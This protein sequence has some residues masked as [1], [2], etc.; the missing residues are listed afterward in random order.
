MNPLP[1]IDSLYSSSPELKKLLLLHSSC[2]ADMAR[3][4]IDSRA[5]TDIDRDFVYE[6][7]MLHDIGIFLCD[8]PSIHCHGTLPYIA[9]GIA[10]AGLLEAYDLPRHALVCERHTG[11]GLSKEDII[12]GNLP[13]PHRDMLPIS[14]EEQLICYADKFYS[15]SGDPGRRKPLDRVM[16]QMES[17]GPATL[18]RFLHL[19]SLFSLPDM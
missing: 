8:A 3:E 17:H 15:K 10:G 4:I 5:L 9:H 12:N 2:V 13:L 14:P 6:A 11:A 18:N 16:A 7:A 1:I 19:H